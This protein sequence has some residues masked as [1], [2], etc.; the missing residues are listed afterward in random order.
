MKKPYLVLIH[1]PGNRCEPHL[2]TEEDEDD[3]IMRAY[4]SRPPI[5]EIGIQIEVYLWGQ[6]VPVKSVNSINTP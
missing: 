4:G 1:S 3:A 6:A 2:V 5:I